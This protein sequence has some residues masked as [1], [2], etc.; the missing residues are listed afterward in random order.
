MKFSREFEDGEKMKQRKPN[1]K[2]VNALQ[3][4]LLLHYLIFLLAYVEL[5]EQESH[6]AKAK[7]NSTIQTEDGFVTF[8]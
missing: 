8:V 6:E 3:L 7:K 5:L 4:V 1:E 2:N